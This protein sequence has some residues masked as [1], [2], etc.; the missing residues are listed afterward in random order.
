MNLYLVQHAEAV[1]KSVDPERPI[2]DKGRADIEKVGAYLKSR[3]EIEVLAVTHS[4]KLRAK[5]TAEVLFRNVGCL[6]GVVAVK[7]LEPDANPAIWKERLGLMQDDVFLVGH[8]PQLQRLAGLLLH[9]DANNTEVRFVN[10]GVVCLHKDGNRWSLAWT[11][12]PD[13]L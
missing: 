5:Q 13:E 6:Q 9:N 8:L 1:D 2:S 10:A 12:T 11:I 7:D 4:G 3:Q